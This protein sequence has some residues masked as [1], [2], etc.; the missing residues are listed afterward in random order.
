MEV[1]R[2]KQ[3]LSLE[4][5]PFIV[6]RLTLKE[7]DRAALDGLLENYE[8]HCLLSRMDAA[9][10]REDVERAL[11][12]YH[13]AGVPLEEAIARLSP[14][15]LGGF[16]ARPPV[17]WFPLDDA[18][19]I[20]PLSMRPGKMAV[21]RLSIYLRQP[22]VPELLQMA[23][24]FTVKRFPSFAT[25]VKSGFFWHY[26]DTAKTRFAVEPDGSIPCQPLDVSR[27]GSASFRVLYHDNRISV[28]FFHILTDGTGG[29]VFL[30]T[31]AGTYLRLKGVSVPCTA[32]V[33]DPDDAPRPGETENAFAAQE[34][35]NTGSGFVDHPAVQ[36]SGSLVRQRPCQVLHFNMEAES[37]LAAAKQRGATVTAYLLTL[38]FLAGQYA[39]DETEGE[40]SIQVPVNMRKF[41]PS[42]TL[43]NFALYG[44]VRLPL[45]QI[46]T[47]EDILPEVSR[48]L[49]EKTGQEAMAE[50]LRA[51][52]V[53]V[54]TIRYIPLVV[55]APAARLVYGFLGDKIF[56]N[57]LSNLGVVELPEELAAEVTH[58][59]FVLGTAL[60]NR[61]SCSLVTCCGVATLSI[62][63]MT[64]DPSF[65]ERLYAL[66]CR[67]GIV[68]RVEGSDLHGH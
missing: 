44:S 55:K 35:E 66:L 41:Y 11:L 15:H 38:M 40:M 49:R 36:L 12:W 43:R 63:K 58:M 23:L 19:K 62:A 22:V 57:T 27:S 51:T 47:A 30:K 5:S 45:G 33:L 9:S 28:E 67:D 42:N 60:T 8:R 59:D 61:A 46:T 24:T 17:T 26:L 52:R 39:T 10:L 21:F 64:A 18:A 68:P 48:Q 31:L 54:N 25:T 53:L 4:P 6:Y 50:M 37:L 20:Y 3:N 1:R 32:G 14:I 2:L 16:Y 7:Q 34:T 56:S 29:M 13:S 65:E